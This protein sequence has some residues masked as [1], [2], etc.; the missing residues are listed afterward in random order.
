M[1]CR[2]RGSREW[3]RSRVHDLNSRSLIG[4][5][6]R[7]DL[8]AC[9]RRGATPVGFLRLAVAQ[10]IFHSCGVL[11]SCGQGRQRRTWFPAKGLPLRMALALEIMKLFTKLTGKRGDELIAI[12][13]L[14]VGR[15]Q[16]RIHSERGQT[17]IND[18]QGR[19]AGLLDVR[20]LVVLQYFGRRAVLRIELQKLQVR[21]YVRFEQ[22]ERLAADK[23]KHINFGKALVEVRVA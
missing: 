22:L 12:F 14:E 9:R 6:R 11:P 19:V 23:H 3:S 7:I 2:L 13:A 15:Y 8:A 5:A 10:P 16:V 18:I 17:G 21:R 1:S 20:V 4:T